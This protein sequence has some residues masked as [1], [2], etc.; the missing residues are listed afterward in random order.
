MNYT[1]VSSKEIISRVYRDFRPATSGWQTDAVEWLGD[2]IERLGALPALEKKSASFTASSFRA[3]LPCD[4]VILHAVE[5][6]GRRLSRSGNQAGYGS[7][8]REITSAWTGGEAGYLLNPGYIILSGETDTGVF[9]YS[10]IP[11]DADGYP[12]VPNNPFLLQACFWYI[13]GRLA[14][15]GDTTR[16]T[17]EECDVKYE[18]YIRL[19]EN[20]IAFPDIDTMEGIRASWVRLIP[21]NG[22][23]ATFG[24]GST[25]FEVR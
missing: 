19:A 5:L 9:H 1:S 17:F 10:A 20:D 2:V 3:P 15:R 21:E 24:A 25:S 14:L 11:T 23:P 18:T 4:M 12:L 13:V 22:Y 7:P 16:V 8:Y 6:D